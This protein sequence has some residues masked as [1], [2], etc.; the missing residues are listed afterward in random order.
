MLPGLL[1]ATEAVEDSLRK[2]IFR[3]LLLWSWATAVLAA[4]AVQQVKEP[5]LVGCRFQCWECAVEIACCNK[6]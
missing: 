1:V 6:L 2:R 3:V 5:I 4:V